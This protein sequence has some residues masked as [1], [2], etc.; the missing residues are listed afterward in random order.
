MGVVG[1][2]VAGV[3]VVEEGVVRGIEG[4]GVVEVGVAVGGRSIIICGNYG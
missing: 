3:G 2:L 4:V 1:S